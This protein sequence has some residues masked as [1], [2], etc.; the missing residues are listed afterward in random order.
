M[1]CFQVLL[2]MQMEG[3]MRGDLGR[4]LAESQVNTCYCVLV[5]ITLNLMY[6]T[7]LQPNR[8]LS[9]KQP[10]Q[11]G[12]KPTAD[13][14]EL[15][16]LH[17]TV[18]GSLDFKQPIKWPKNCVGVLG[19]DMLWGVRTCFEDNKT[20]TSNLYQSYPSL[21]P[22]LLLR[23]IAIYCVPQVVWEDEPTSCHHALPA[24][25]QTSPCSILHK[26]DHQ[27][28]FIVPPHHSSPTL[29]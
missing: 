21:P 25:T 19:V 18:Y 16:W 26:E 4:R 12:R 20:F 10:S 17:L 15:T 13:N 22:S 3:K 5:I 28:L 2:W 29:I 11:Y 9:S 1:A 7:I 27:L 8:V 24:Q 6:L 14:G 23:N